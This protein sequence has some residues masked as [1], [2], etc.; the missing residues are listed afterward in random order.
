MGLHQIGLFGGPEIILMLRNVSLKTCCFYWLEDKITNRR[1][2]VYIQC[3]VTVN[4]VR[5]LSV[6]YD[7]DSLFSLLIIAIIKS[8]MQYLEISLFVLTWSCT[9]LI[10]IFIESFNRVLRNIDARY[11]IVHLL[12]LFVIKIETLYS[13]P[14]LF[15]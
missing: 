15:I 8:E 12:L 5:N 9:L 14:C 3:N 2:E 1:K 11:K 4:D 10:L 7:I 13:E 6:C